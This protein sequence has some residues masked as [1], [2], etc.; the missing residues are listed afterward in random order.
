MG[1]KKYE[2]GFKVTLHEDALSEPRGWRKPALC[3]VC[4]MADLFHKDV[5]FEFIDNVMAVIKETPQHTYQLLTKR[6]ERM[7]EYFETRPIPTNVWLGV[8][9]ED[10]SVKYRIDILR[11]LK[12]SIKFLSVEPLV[13]DLGELNLKG[14]ELSSAEKVSNIIIEKPAECK[15]SEFYL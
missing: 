4:S 10:G 7:A 6:A 15:R 14:I 11:P 12:A 9:V 8:T 13:G 3:F 1:D 5:P 2:N